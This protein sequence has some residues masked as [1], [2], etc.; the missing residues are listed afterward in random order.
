VSHQIFLKSRRLER[1]SYW[2]RHGSCVHWS[3]VSPIIHYPTRFLLSASSPQER[4]EGTDDDRDN[5]GLEYCFEFTSVPTTPS[6]FPEF[7]LPRSS[8]RS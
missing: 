2:T 5:R 7:D 1:R 8:S 4:L 6:E 3:I